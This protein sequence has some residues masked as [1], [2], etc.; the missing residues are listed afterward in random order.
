MFSAFVSR[1][2]EFFHKKREEAAFRF[3][4]PYIAKENEFCEEFRVDPRLVCIA[5]PTSH[6]AEQYRVLRT[7]IQAIFKDTSF[8]SLLITSSL[9]AEGKTVTSSNLAIVFSRHHEGRRVVLVDCDMRRPCVS[10]LFKVETSPGLSE[11]LAQGLDFRKVL[12]EKIKDRLWIIPAGRYI[13]GPAELLESEAFN[14]FFEE[15][16]RE[17]DLV[18]LDSPPLISVT[19]AGIL[20]SRVDGVLLVVRALVTQAPD[21]EKARNLLLE[22]RGKLIGVVLVGVENFI[23]Y[24]FQRY[25]YM[26]KYV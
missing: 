11:I 13:E 7:N 16:K 1:I 20:S 19:D 25:S 24:Y 2:K 14:I 10:T 22:A 4:A 18:V 17:F 26:Y 5:E 9:R 15:L 12:R 23:P 21:I 8:K 3:D 6:V